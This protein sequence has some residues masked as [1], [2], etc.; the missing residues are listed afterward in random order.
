M[1]ILYLYDK[2]KCIAQIEDIL[3]LS[4]ELKLN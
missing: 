1:F 3:E 4:C 2:K